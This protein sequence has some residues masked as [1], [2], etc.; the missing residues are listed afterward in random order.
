VSQ[1]TAV[2]HTK[3][4]LPIESTLDGTVHSQTKLC[5]HR[6]KNAVIAKAKP[7]ISTIRC[8]SLST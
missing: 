8:P 5:V 4:S 6:K 2:F 7:E 1:R 3:P